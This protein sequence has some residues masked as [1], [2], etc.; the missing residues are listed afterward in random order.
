MR[1]AVP[2]YGGNDPYI[3][4]SFCKE[5]EAVA[6]PIIE[7][8]AKSGYRVW[9]D[10]GNIPDDVW[11][12]KVM[13]RLSNSRVCIALLSEASVNVHAC[14]NDINM[15]LELGV[16]VVPVLMEEFSMTLAM[17]LLAEKTPGVKAYTFSLTDASGM[18]KL[19]KATLKPTECG[20]CRQAA[21]RDKPWTVTCVDPNAQKKPDRPKRIPG[22][23]PRLLNC[24][25][26]MEEPKEV[27]SKNQ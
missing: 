16:L 15:A 7:S 9:Y 11:A 21:F 14:R 2:P 27:R 5:D 26:H 13:E 3:Y 6:G 18:E 12:E 1:C 24:T 20:L 22:Y 25:I 4:F 17:R 23:N 8:M 10:G 19:L